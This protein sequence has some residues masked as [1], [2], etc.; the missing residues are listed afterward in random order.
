MAPPNLNSFSFALK[1]DAQIIS[2]LELQSHRNRKLIQD[3]FSL[4]FARLDS[5]SQNVLIKLINLYFGS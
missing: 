4:N 2:T 3:F 1:I 5:T